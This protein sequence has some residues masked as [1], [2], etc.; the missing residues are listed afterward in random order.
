MQVSGKSMLPTSSSTSGYDPRRGSRPT[1][2]QSQSKLQMQSLLYGNGSSE[3]DNSKHEMD[4]ILNRIK[5]RK[6]YSGKC[7]IC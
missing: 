6:F 2:L 4:G 1:T 7:V 5:F 3:I